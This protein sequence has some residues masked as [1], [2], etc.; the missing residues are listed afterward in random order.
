[1][2]SEQSGSR[3]C[4]ASLHF[5]WAAA[6]AGHEEMMRTIPSELQ[7]KLEGGVT[8]LCR[9]WVLTRRDGVVLGFTDHDEDVTLSDVTFGDV[10]CRAGA[11][12]TASEATQQLGL[13][14]TATEISG[15]LSDEALGED[16]LAAGRYDAARVD[17]Y[18]VDWSDPSLN[19]LQASATLGE[20]RREGRA[21]TAELRGVADRL[22]Q[23]SGRL[24]TAACSA[25]FGDGACGIDLDNDQ[26]RGSGAVGTLSGTSA[27]VASGLGDFDADWFT[28][29]KLTWSGGTN[30]GLSI[31]VKRHRVDD[32]AVTIEL[33]QA[34][35]YPLTV[36]DSFV[37]TTGC[38]KK[39]E[40]CRNRFNNAVNFRGFPH[41]PGNDFVASYA[42]EGE[43]GHDGK[44]M[45]T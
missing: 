17:I 26:F 6:R 41:I 1:M 12:L 38:D 14:V 33:W 34:M 3:I 28:G 36:A 9:C 18:I 32:G 35:P 44:S 8:T 30:E 37:V 31:E 2:V 43:P 29:G 16:D 23:E 20:I 27:F 13:A 15:A 25:D 4:A 21:F 19:V 5:A 22:S 10:L 39:F 45:Q 40:T 42:L 7:A 24:Y 11:G